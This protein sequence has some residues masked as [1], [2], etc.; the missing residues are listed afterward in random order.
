MYPCPTDDTHTH[1]HLSPTPPPQAS[2]GAEDI[3]DEKVKVLRSMQVVKLEDMVLGQYRGRTGKGQNLPGYL[4][5]ATVPPN[6][7]ERG[8]GGG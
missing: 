5:D 2:L 4:D 3:R 1:P 6:R 8:K 7:S